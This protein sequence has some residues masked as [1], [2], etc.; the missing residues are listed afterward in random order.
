MIPN[1]S[2]SLEFKLLAPKAGLEP[3]TFNQLLKTLDFFLHAT[4]YLVSLSQLSYLGRLPAD[5]PQSAEG[6]L[7]YA[8]YSV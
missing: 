4:D 1:S 7:G 6:I 3:A 5:N 8:Y 2:I